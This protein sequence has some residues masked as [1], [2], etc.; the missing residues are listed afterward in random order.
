MAETVNLYNPDGRILPVHVDDGVIYRPG[1]LS[2]THELNDD[3]TLTL[4][5]GSIFELTD[6]SLTV[7]IT[8]I[9]EN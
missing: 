9:A 6:A 4:S 2:D 3:G 7:L 5:D 1:K 8:A